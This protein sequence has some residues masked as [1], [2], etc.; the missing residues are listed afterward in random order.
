MYCGSIDSS[1]DSEFAG[2]FFGEGTLDFHVHAKGYCYPRLRISM[3]SWEMPTLQAIQAR[4]GGSVR[5]SRNDQSVQW[6]ITGNERIRPLVEI[7]THA[8]LPS[9]KK[10]ELEIIRRGMALVSP[11]G[12]R[13]PLPGEQEK[14]KEQ[15][16]ELRQQ[17]LDLRRQVRETNA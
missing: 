13:R 2:L 17:L 3:A 9:P 1:F 16:Q 6:T 12:G 14:L 11:R 7:L 5:F 10:A 8:S 15:M 4:Y